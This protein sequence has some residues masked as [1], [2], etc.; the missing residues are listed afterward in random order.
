LLNAIYFR[1]RK[2]NIS[3]LV[4]FI[5]ILSVIYLARR[6]CLSVLVEFIILS[7]I[8]NIKGKSSAFF[9]SLPFLLGVGV[10]ITLYFYTLPQT[11]YTRLD[12]RILEDSRQNLYP[13]FLHEM[14]DYIYFGKG[15]NGKY[16]Y[17]MEAHIFENGSDKGV[18]FNDAIFR[19]SAENG[20]LQLMLSG[21][22]IHIILFVLILFPAAF[23]VF[24][25]H[26]ISFQKHVALLS[27]FN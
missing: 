3:F 10:F 21:G 27:C 4:V 26:L 19:N 18:V 16:Y 24:L 9:I 23:M 22:I 7:Y 2:I 5:A 15:L 13:S 6:S 8:F 14:S 1:N 25:N 20:Y 17:P 12:E 11:L